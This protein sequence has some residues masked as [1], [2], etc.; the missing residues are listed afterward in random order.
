MAS[1]GARL[2]GEKCVGGVESSLEAVVEGAVGDVVDSGRDGEDENSLFS[3]IS[4]LERVVE[5]S[6]EAV[7]EGAVGA[8]A[9]SES[10]GEDVKSLLMR[11]SA[12]EGAVVALMEEKEA[13]KEEKEAWK[14][15]KEV[16]KEEKE[17][18]KEENESLKDE[19]CV[20]RSQTPKA[21]VTLGGTS[22]KGWTVAGK[23]GSRVSPRQP[24]R[25]QQVVSRNSF[26]VLSELEEG[27][28]E[29]KVVGGGEVDGKSQPGGNI[30]VV[31][32]SQ[33]RYLDRAF[34][35]KDRK[36]RT[37]VCFPGAGVGEVSD[38]IE[39]CMANEGIKPIVC[40]NAGGN[41][42]GKVCSEELLRRFKEVLGK[43]R[44]R[45]GIPV[46]CGILPRRGVGCE[47]LSRAIAVNCRLA[48]HCKANGWTF[49]DNWNRFF[50]MDHLYQWDGVHLSW[51]GNQLLAD[52]LDHETR[53]LKGFLG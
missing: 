32:D 34:C 23:K 52:S 50:G 21:D 38:R 37:R 9:G 28:E 10:V 12:L 1:D 30:L 41:D 45:G 35:A 18:L 4:A 19:V 43:V 44:D 5:S 13:W 53:A 51:R 22:D 24:V 2:C 17:A 47:W 36:H 7:V 40:L 29:V 33:V 48:D 15:E 49:V 20:L 14:E 3:R 46:V 16:L 25:D 26:H 27:E 31:G 42:V 39:A 8:I 11:V 6:L